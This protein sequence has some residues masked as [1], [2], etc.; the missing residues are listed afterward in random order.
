MIYTLIRRELAQ[1]RG[2]TEADFGRDSAI[3]G[4]ISVRELAQL[5]MACERE[6][7]VTVHDEDA[8]DFRCVADLEE[9]IRRKMQDG[10]EGVVQRTQR[11]RDAWF[12]E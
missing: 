8:P 2:V 5:L 6:F 7:A 4:G 11:E 12:Y 3:A 1:M 9:H 10:T